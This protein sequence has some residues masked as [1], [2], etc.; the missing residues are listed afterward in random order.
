MKN[1]K[2]KVSLEEAAVELITDLSIGAVD[3]LG[4][5]VKLAGSVNEI[6][7]INVDV[8]RGELN[9]LNS[10]IQSAIAE[11]VIGNDEEVNL[12]DEFAALDSTHSAGSGQTGSSQANSATNGND[13]KVENISPHIAIRQ[14][15]ILEFIRQLPS[16][17]RMKDLATRFPEVSERTLRNDLQTLSAEGFLERIGKGPFGSFRAVT[18]QEIIAL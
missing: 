1:F 4:T 14:S 8:L 13:G 15:A 6:K 10:M 17:C 9:S 18:K 16:G 11:S 2:I 7:P 3:K 5:L 12:E